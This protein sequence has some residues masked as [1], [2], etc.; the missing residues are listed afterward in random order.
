MY[1][2][3]RTNL[4]EITLPEYWADLVDEDS[5]SVQITPVRSKLTYFVSYIGVDKICVEFDSQNVEYC[6]LVQASRKDETFEV[7]FPVS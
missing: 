2:R 6:Y 1:V 4:S 7:E 5:I 3:G